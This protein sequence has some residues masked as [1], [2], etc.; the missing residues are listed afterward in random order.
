[1]LKR[2]KPKLWLAGL[3]PALLLF[4]FNAQ[5][6]IKDGL[7]AYWEFDDNYE[8]SIGENHGEPQGATSICGLGR[9]PKST[10]RSHSMKRS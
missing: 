8:D 2:C 7:V 4:G 6:A 3:I 1:M 5:A 10:N 9:N